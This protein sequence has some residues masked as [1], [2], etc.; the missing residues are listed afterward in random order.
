[1]PG[2]HSNTLPIATRR[3][4]LHAYPQVDGAVAPLGRKHGLALAAYLSLRGQPVGRDV[5][6]ALLWPDAPSGRGRGRLRRLVHELNGALADRLVEGDGDALWLAPG[7]RSDVQVTRAAIA[8]PD[9]HA[10]PTLC[11]PAAAGLLEGFAL[12]GSDAFDDW[13]DGERCVQRAALGH[14]LERLL[15]AALDAHDADAAEHTAQAL[16][17]LD[18]GA[19]AGHIARLQARALR[20]DAAGVEAAYFDGAE[21][22]RADYGLRPSARVEAAYAGARARLAASRPETRYAATA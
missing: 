22:W 3:L 14:A 17:H 15:A 18:A 4:A 6:A 2:M 19:E 8:A 13:L 5:L 20:G 10:L 21:R 16:L 12:A 11:A 1:M 9:L 7:W